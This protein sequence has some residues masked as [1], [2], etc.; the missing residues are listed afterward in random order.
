[1]CETVAL[2]E[3][4]KGNGKVAMAEG[5][6]GNNSKD[7]IADPLSGCPARTIGALGGGKLMSITEMSPKM[8]LTWS[9]GVW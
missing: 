1:M 3:C 8:V 5:V 6:M 9:N 7:A 4:C 2:V